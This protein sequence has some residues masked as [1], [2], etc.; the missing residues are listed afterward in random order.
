[1]DNIEGENK[2]GTAPV[3][4]SFLAL[5][6]TDLIG[7]LNECSGFLNK[8]SYPAPNKALLSEEG[9]LGNLRFLLSSI[10]SKEAAASDLGATVYNI[11]CI[12]MEAYATIKIDEYNAKFLFRPAIY[13]GPL[14]QNVSAGWKMA[15][16]PRITNDL[17]LQNLR[18]TLST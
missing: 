7:D 6:S 3:R 8:W 12:G 4:D 13:D 2:F 15:E 5:A 16:V 10:G 17:W 9:S 1:M 14:M 18:T 11:F